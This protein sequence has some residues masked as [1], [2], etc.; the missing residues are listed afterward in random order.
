M[1]SLFTI[2]GL[3]VGGTLVYKALTYNAPPIDQLTNHL[4]TTNN[5]FVD[6]NNNVNADQWATML[7]PHSSH[8]VYYQHPIPNIY[9]IRIDNQGFQEID[10]S[11]WKELMRHKS[12][13]KLVEL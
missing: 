12:N 6:D 2:A 3:A 4:V 10:S 11:G 5:Y 1:T 7:N 9:Y 8:T 13:F